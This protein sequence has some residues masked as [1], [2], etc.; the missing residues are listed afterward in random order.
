MKDLFSDLED[1]PSLLPNKSLLECLTEIV[2]Q[3]RRELDREAGGHGTYYLYPKRIPPCILPEAAKLGSA[4]DVSPERALLFSLIVDMAEG[5]MISRSVL[6]GNL[7]GGYVQSLSYEKDLE[8]LVEARLIN[9]TSRGSVEV[10]P[11]A[12]KAIMDNKPYQ[13]PDFSGMTTFTILLRLSRLFSEIE[14]ENN[15]L[16][17]MLRDIWEMLSLNPTTSIAQASL[18]YDIPDIDEK[19]QALFFALLFLYQEENN[20]SVEWWDLRDYFDEGVLDEMQVSY[21]YELLELQQKDILVYENREGLVQKG[22]FKLADSVKEALLADCGGLR[23]TKT[24]SDLIAHASIAEKDLF[25]DTATTRRIEE[26]EKL[27]RQ[28][29]YQEVLETLKSSSLRTGFTCLFYGV[30]GTGKTETAYQLARRTG[31]SILTV[32]VSRL[33]SQWV[34]E[35]EKNI[36]N[37]FS[38]Y[39]LIVRDAQIAPILLFNEADAIFGLRRAGADRAVDK[40]ENTLQNILLQ[41]MEQLEGILIATT[42]LTRNLDKAF[43][44]RFLYKIRFDIPSQEV[45]SQIWHAMMPDLSNAEAGILAGA[46]NFTGGQIENILRKRAIRA[47]L[48]GSPPTFED[49]LA[50]CREEAIVGEKPGRKIGFR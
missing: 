26:L 32:D 46:F 21:K 29:R 5:D 28:D 50:F 22:R 2:G 25:Y 18:D 27:L 16:E 14:H 43:E 33:K 31:R 6:A 39:R 40:M 37:L 11:E 38:R 1:K 42:N 45:K 15:T 48:D 12:L 49:L 13:R 19:E 44:R 47:I 34:G 20:D 17:Q 24:A 3:C 30:P 4:L 10:R 41:E 7:G 8:Q 23:E 35:S 9:R 36:K